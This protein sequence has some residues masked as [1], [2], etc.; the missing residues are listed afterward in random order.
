MRTP[1][2]SIVIPT[3]DRPHT[4]EHT[5]A[6]CRVQEGPEFEIVVSDNWS[7]P[8]TRELVE[9][10]A[11]TRIRYVRTPAPLAMT[12]SLEF[13]VAQA[14]GEYV[15]MQGDDDGLLRHALPVIDSVL[16]ATNTPL[17]RWVSAAYNWPD[18]DNPHVLPNRLLLPLTQA[19]T[20]HPLSACNSRTMM[21]AAVN[22]H[23]SYSELPIIYSA[24]IQRDLVTR[25][26][27]RTGRVFKTRTPDVHA[28]FAL[29]A[30]V[31]QYHSLGAPLGICGRSGSSTGVARH[32]CKKGSPIDNEFRRLNA[33]AG[34]ELHPWVP[35][36]PPIPAAVADAFL[37]AKHDLFPDDDEVVLDRSRLIRNCLHE[38]EVDTADEWGEVQAKCRQALADSPDLLTWFEREYGTMEFTALRPA[39]RSHHWRRYGE[40][41]LHLDTAEFGVADIDGAA[42]LCERVLGYKRDGLIFRLEAF[43]GVKTS[44]SELEE[45]EAV[46]QELQS[47]CQWL[48]GQNDTLL[49]RVHEQDARLP[50]HVG[51]PDR[52]PEH[53]DT[54]TPRP[55]GWRGWGGRLGSVARRVL[56]R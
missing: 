27:A 11:D 41:Y 31:D 16:R 50:K 47:H 8:R 25:L 5:L 15:L 26:G 3:R 28:A 52:Q 23:A 48:R 21:H 19:R 40:G 44:L 20:G 39:Y 35:D 4:L 10:C 14:R 18:V 1:R 34:Y 33:E 13:A 36:L 12:D 37:W 45:K 24:A 32:F 56:P 49:R 7:S 6:T 22:G 46:I 51:G 38:L 30:L 9:R 54:L 55:A 42:D 17:L 29:T 2:F 43:D 53:V